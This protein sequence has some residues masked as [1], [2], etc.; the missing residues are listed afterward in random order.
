MTSAKGLLFYQAFIDESFPLE[1][2]I[3]TASGPVTCQKLKPKPLDLIKLFFV[4]QTFIEHFQA[5]GIENNTWS[6]SSWK[7]WFG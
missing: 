6:Q 3:K 1:L 2:G 5:L 4:L 7:A